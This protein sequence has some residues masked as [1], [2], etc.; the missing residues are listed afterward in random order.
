MEGTIS[1]PG[2]VIK[3]KDVLLEG[4]R[5]EKMLRK[6]RLQCAVPDKHLI[7]KLALQIGNRYKW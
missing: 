1:H 7:T 6:M 5:G 3:H 4:A 2:I